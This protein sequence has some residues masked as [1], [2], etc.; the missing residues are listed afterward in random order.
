M[1]TS[2]VSSFAIVYYALI[3]C[4]FS[5]GYFFSDVFSSSYFDMLLGD[6]E[7]EGDAP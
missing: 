7:G 3:F 5:F 2:L 6:L 4:Y 1:A